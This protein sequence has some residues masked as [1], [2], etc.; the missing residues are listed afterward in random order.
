MPRKS[1]KK[2]A[3]KSMTVD[4]IRRFA[5]NKTAMAA[6]VFLIL[7]ALVAIFADVIVDYNV[8]ITQNITERFKAPGKAH[9]L[10]TDAFGRDVLARIIHGSRISLLIGL[11]T[12]SV[13]LIIACILGSAAA[14]YGNM[15]DN[16]IMRCIDVLIS[17][18]SILLT[19]CL[20]SILGSNAFNLGV[21]LMIGQIPS[22]TKIVRS[23]VLNV[24]GSD[25]IE[26]ARACGSSDAR[27]IATH[28]LPNALGP[29][30]VQGTM[31]ISGAILTASGLSFIGL[32]CQPPAPEWGVML[33]EAKEKMLMY[34]YLAIIPGIA[35]VL[36]ALGFNLMGDGLRD[37]LDPKLKD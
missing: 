30:I 28:I 20:V 2:A 22:F 19:I 17:I 21:A 29:I 26:A 25:Y 27:I 34:P 31:N 10:G 3:S 37:A 1:K 35:I 18:P 5:S 24:K 23:T 15:V 8:S 13:S 33:S 4:I 36:T 11:G 12:T 14:Y 16:V 7:V 6:F 9:I 32:G